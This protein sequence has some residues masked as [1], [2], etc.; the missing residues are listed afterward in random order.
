M[1]QKRAQPYKQVRVTIRVIFNK[2]STRDN[3]ICTEYKEE[4]D[5]LFVGKFQ[6]V[7]YLNLSFIILNL[8]SITQRNLQAK[9]KGE[10]VF[11]T[12]IILSTKFRMYETSS[13][14][15]H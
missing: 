1:V 14:H 5:F 6:T 10:D 8:F 12:A 2:K 15:I 9:E 7:L 3:E 11:K 13:A 4:R